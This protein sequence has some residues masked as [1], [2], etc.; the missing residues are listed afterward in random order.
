M[1]HIF[2]LYGTSVLLSLTQPLLKGTQVIPIF[3]KT[4]PLS[5]TALLVAEALFVPTK[6]SSSR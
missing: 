1:K 4:C 2:Q 6:K 3:H 5:E